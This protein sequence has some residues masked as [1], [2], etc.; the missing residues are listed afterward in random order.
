MTWPF[1]AASSASR[2]VEPQKMPSFQ[3][4]KRDL[5]HVGGITA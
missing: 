2:F 4:G 1:I 3:L 5:N